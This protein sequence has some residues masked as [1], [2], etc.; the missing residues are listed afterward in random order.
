MQ[1]SFVKLWSQLSISAINHINL[2][3]NKTGSCREK[4][5]EA[6]KD[7]N[8]KWYIHMAGNEKPLRQR[9]LQHE[10]KKTTLRA[11]EEK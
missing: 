7:S 5:H 1:C 11:E 10:A 4:L 8:D 3:G 9:H 2:N 6:C